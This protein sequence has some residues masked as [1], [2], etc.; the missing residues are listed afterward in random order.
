MNIGLINDVLPLRPEDLAAEASAVHVRE[1]YRVSVDSRY[2][3][4]V[5]PCVL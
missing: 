1:S 4:P 3:W 2:Y 5:L